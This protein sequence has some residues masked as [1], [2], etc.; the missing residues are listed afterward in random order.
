MSSEQKNDPI[1]KQQTFYNE[2]IENFG[3]SSYLCIYYPEIYRGI[4]VFL[5]RLTSEEYLKNSY[6]L[7]FAIC[8]IDRA[9]RRIKELSSSNEVRIF[10]IILDSID[11]ILIHS[12]RPRSF[13]NRCLGA[14]LIFPYH[15][16]PFI[17]WLEHDYIE[18]SFLAGRENYNFLVDLLSTVEKE[19]AF[20]A[21]SPRGQD[22]K[23][24]IFECIVPLLK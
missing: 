16:E 14:E 15:F 19:I 5:L 2:L 1:A 7:D 10:E 17:K 21:K 9:H 6:T 20:L 24:K 13:T 22:L 23:K 18:E 3:G 11:Q 12:K 4:C 8:E